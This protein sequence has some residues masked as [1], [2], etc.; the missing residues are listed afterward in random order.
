MG[1]LHHPTMLNPLAMPF[2]LNFSPGKPFA[3]ARHALIRIRGTD[4]RSFL[5]AQCMNDVNLLGDGDWQYNGWLNP[6]GRV[7]ALFYLMRENSD[8]YYM[9]VPEL[10]AEPLIA[11]LQR[12][13]FRSKLNLSLDTEQHLHGTLLPATSGQA[14]DELQSGT[15]EA[16]T[17]RIP[18]RTT[19]RLLSIAPTPAAADPDAL[20][21]W[22]CLDLQ[23]G[24][25]WLGESMQNRWTPQMLSL[26]RLNAFSLNKGCYPGQEIVARTHY[27]G[28]SKRRLQSIS[29]TGMQTDQPLTV[30]GR[31]FGRITDVNADGSF[32]VAVINADLPTGPWLTTSG[33]AV[34]PLTD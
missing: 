3:L 9:V 16:L 8:A 27:L 25:V 2:K 15:P 22:H 32:G 23:T 31:E 21:L 24:W 29:G 1:L 26:D 11:S 5:Q 17:W 30:S 34:Y 4:A 13:T 14:T 20:E 33:A 19:D 10:P 18:G 7:M 6:Q 28:K 12:Y